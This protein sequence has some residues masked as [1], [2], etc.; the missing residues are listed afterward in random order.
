MATALTHDTYQAFADLC[1]RLG[2]SPDRD[3]ETH[4]ACPACG[5]E[6]KR[7]HV[8]FSF[9]ERGGK[10]FVCDAHYGIF[11]LRRMLLGDDPKP[12]PIRPVQRP[13]ASIDV[14]PGWK[15]YPTIWQ[16]FLHLPQLAR[17]YYH[18][19]GFSDETITR[20]RLG[21]GILPSSRCRFLRLIL[22]VFVDGR[23]VAIRGRALDPQDQGD[24][25]LCSRG[26]QT[27]LFGADTLETG[28]IVIV[29]EAPYSAILAHQNR[30]D[31]AAVAGTGG[32]ACWREEWSQQIAESDPAWC[33][34]WYDAD[35]A[36]EINGERVAKSLRGA[37]L[38][39]QV[40]RWRPGTEKKRDLADV[41]AAGEH[42][43]VAPR[44]P[45]QL[46]DGI[47]PAWSLA[48]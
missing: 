38:R 4:I 15:A 9:S 33:L 27:V 32:A 14:E 35:E 39:V 11:A 40:W 41:L 7:G 26:S 16:T 46:V 42:L 44:R 13:P 48:R 10:C 20:W 45:A 28:R 31:L 36:G 30:P 22:P 3:G 8:H 2:V 5:K 47:E 21:Y 17:D 37:G 34:V 6:P 1:Y 25:W 19:R 24:K 23:L 18:G 29:T 12:I 43:P